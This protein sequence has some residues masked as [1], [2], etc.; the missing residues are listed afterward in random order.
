MG[1]KGLPLAQKDSAILLRSVL[2]LRQNDM[3]L[4]FESLPAP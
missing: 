3:M 1:E 4:Q 2:L